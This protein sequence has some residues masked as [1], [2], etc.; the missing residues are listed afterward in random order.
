MI[1]GYVNSE[2]EAVIP[3]V[4]Y[5]PQGA[6]REIEAVIDTGF[7]GD[8]TLPSAFV[9]ALRVDILANEHLTLADGSEVA[10]EICPA[11]VVWDGQPRII[12]VSTLETDP[13]VGM[14]LLEGYNLNVQVAVGGR[15]TIEPFSPAQPPS[16]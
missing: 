14:G 5:G 9:A 3:I 13:L 1:T 7:T 8:L 12:E 4:V 6:M 11:I 10:S 2:R 15:V 16:A